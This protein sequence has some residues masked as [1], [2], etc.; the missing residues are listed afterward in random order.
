MKRIWDKMHTE[1][2]FVFD[3]YYNKN[4]ADPQITIPTERICFVSHFDMCENCEN[5]M[6]KFLEQMEECKSTRFNENSK[7]SYKILVGSFVQYGKS[8]ERNSESKLLKIKRVLS[9]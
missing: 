4:K 7:Y 9:K 8:R 2:L 1:D 6:I 5:L 3:R